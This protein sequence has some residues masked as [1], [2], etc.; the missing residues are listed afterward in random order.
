MFESASQ[1]ASS[2]IHLPMQELEIYNDDL[3]DC[4]FETSSKATSGVARFNGVF[5]LIESNI[6]ITNASPTHHTHPSIVDDD[7]VQI[8]V[9]VRLLRREPA[10]IPEHR[11]PVHKIPRLQHLGPAHENVPAQHPR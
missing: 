4:K 8:D 6:H 3:L 9:L 10:S 2:C 1:I 5:C 11:Q 7:I